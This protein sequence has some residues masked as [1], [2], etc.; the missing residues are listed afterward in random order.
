MGCVFPTLFA[1]E[2]TT[3][4]ISES[5]ANHASDGLIGPVLIVHTN[6]N[7]VAVAEIELCQIAVQML[8]RAS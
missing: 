5:L 8:I 4:P 6:P 3:P 7:A 2:R 1:M